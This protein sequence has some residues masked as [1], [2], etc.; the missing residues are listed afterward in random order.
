MEVSEGYVGWKK[1]GFFSHEQEYFAVVAKHLGLL[2]EA[3]GRW[4]R[5]PLSFLTE[6]AD[7]ICYRII[8][9]EDGFEVRQLLAGE[10]KD[11]LVEIAKPKDKCYY[12]SL[13]DREK[14]S[15]LRALALSALIKEISGIFIDNYSE[16]MSGQ[17]GDAL[18]TY[19]KWVQHLNKI[20]ETTK[21]RVYRSHLVLASEISGIEA[22]RGLLDEFSGIVI[23][24]DQKGFRYKELKIKNQRMNKFFTLGLEDVQDLSTAVARVVDYI[25][26]MTDRYA[27]SSYRKVKGMSLY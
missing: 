23:E 13:A 19:S 12:N 24:L 2:Q 4:R 8:D 17:F 3:P 21:E 27:I 11:L 5:H 7:D 26:G 15:Y 20:L 16:I 6:A 1:H 25:A 9:L 22:I 14:I 10:V 18:I